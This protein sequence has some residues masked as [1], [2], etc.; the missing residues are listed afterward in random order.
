VKSP[1]LIDE[2]KCSIQIIASKIVF[3]YVGIREITGSNNIF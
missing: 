3:E 1:K 2:A